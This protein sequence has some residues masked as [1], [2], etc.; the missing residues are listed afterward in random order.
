MVPPWNPPLNIGQWLQHLTETREVSPLDLLLSPIRDMSY[1]CDLLA[2][3]IQARH[4]EIEQSRK[5]NVSE[6]SSGIE[7]P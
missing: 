6:P 7:G 4:N 1:F 5:A 3:G 2:K